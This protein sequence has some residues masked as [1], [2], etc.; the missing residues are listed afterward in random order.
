MPHEYSAGS[1]NT[2]KNAQNAELVRPLYTKGAS[3]KSVKSA[4][5]G[6]AKVREKCRASARPHSDTNPKTQK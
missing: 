4:E 6:L 1:K 3:G 5:P 2:K